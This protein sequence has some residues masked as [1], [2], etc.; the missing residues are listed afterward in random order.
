MRRENET[1]GSGGERDSLLLPM[2]LLRSAVVLAFA[3]LA[4]GFWLLQ[5]AQHEKYRRLAENNHQRTIAL[6]APRGVV[7]DRDG[8]VLV[9]NR[10]SLNISLVREQVEDIEASIELLAEVAGVPS[11]DLWSVVERHRRDPVYRP[12]VL[13]RDASLGQVAAVA[14]HALELPGLFVQQLPTRY[15]P[16]GEVAAHLFGYVGE[17]SDAQLASAEFQNVRSG[18]VVGKSGMEQTYNQFLM[19]RDGARRVVVDSIG[20]EIDTIGEVAANEGRQLQLTLDYDLQQAAEDAFAVA[21]FHGAAVALDPRAGEILALVSLP[22]YDPN[23]FALGIDQDTWNALNQDELRPLTNR[24]LQGTYPPGS[25]FKIAMVVAA[26]EEGIVTPNFRVS[27]RGGGTFYG[28]FSECHT[29]HGSVDMREALE[30]SCNTYFYTLG[31]MLEIDQIHKWA[32]ALGLGELSGL[33]LPHEVQGLM[34]STAWKRAARGEPWYPGETI[35]VAIGQGAVS[36]TPISMAVMMATVANGGTRVTPHLLKA[37]NDGMGWTPWQ[38]PGPQSEVSLSATTLSTVTDGLWYVVNRAGTG[39]RGRIEGRDVIGKTGTA[40]VISLQGRIAAGDTERDLR[41]HGWFVFAA[42]AGA[43][44]IA[45]VVFGEHAEH[46]YLA[47]PIAKHVMETYFAKQEG[48]PRP[49]LPLPARPQVLPPVVAVI[50]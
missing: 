12:I 48:R 43:P 29:T 26:L 8:R 18:S 35:S 39:R 38:P 37:V 14:A 31:E 1:N 17:V 11:S 7:F 33:D 9:E 47:A 45:G 20:R 3:A 21:G 23:A 49:V 10:D 40:Q 30:Q 5:V 36:V 25:T 16:A 42:P 32:T 46:G 50:P 27:C 44:E 41:D 19:G 15:Y 22:A 6:T 13:I 28:R 4:V 2:T 34:P 24:A